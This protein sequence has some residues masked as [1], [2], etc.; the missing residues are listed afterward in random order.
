MFELF[1]K[2]INMSYTDD[3]TKQ[4]KTKHEINSLFNITFV[5]IEFVCFKHCKYF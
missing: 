1:Y 5:I 4:I 2:C 3:C